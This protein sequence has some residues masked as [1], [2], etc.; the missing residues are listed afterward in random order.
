M[1]LSVSPI[2]LIP[3]LIILSSPQSLRSEEFVS[4][5]KF[6]SNVK[7]DEDEL[8][9]VISLKEA[10]ALRPDVVDKAIRELYAT[11][12][13]RSI[14]V[15]GERAEERIIITF[16]LYGKDIV[17]QI[18]FEGNRFITSKRLRRNIE[19]EVNKLYYED[20]LKK[21]VDQIIGLY[22]DRSFFRTNVKPFIKGEGSGSVSVDFKIDEGSMKNIDILEFN[23]EIEEVREIFNKKFRYGDVYYDKDKFEESIEAITEYLIDRGY[24]NIKI[25]SPELIYES[26]R[27]VLKVRLNIEPGIKYQ[28]EFKGNHAYETDELLKLINF[29]THKSGFSSLL[30]DEWKQKLADV[31]QRNGYA[32][33]SVEIAEI[34]ITKNEHILSFK[35]NEG[36]PMRVKEIKFQGNKYFDDDRIKGMMLTKERGLFSGN[37]DFI[38]D[39]M[40]DYYPKGILIQSRLKEDIENIEY[41]YKEAGFLNASINIK[42]IDYISDNGEIVINILIREGERIF[43]KDVEFEGNSTFTDDELKKIVKIEPRKPFN[44]WIADEGIKLLKNHYDEN[45][46]IFSKIGIENIFIEG[47]NEV[48][49]KYNIDEGPEAYVS[50]VFISGN[51]VTK[52]YVLRRELSFSEGD[53]L[54]PK[55][56]FESQRKIYRLGFIDR[57]SIDIKN[58]EPDGATDI[59][60]K[61]KESKFNRFDIRFGYGTAEGLRSSIEFTK[62][63]LGGRGQTIFARADISYWL[64]D[65]NPFSDIFNSEENYFNTKIFNVGFI[66]PWLFRQNMDLRINYINQER[67]RIY[68]LRSNDIIL[69][70]ERDL[71]RHYH[72][73]VQYQVRFRDPI[74]DIQPDLR[75]EEKRRLGFLGFF[76][77]HDTRNNPFEPYK[78]HLQTYRIDFASRNLVPGGEYDYL[79]F[80]IKGDFFTRPIKK[81]VTA[82]SVRSGYGYVLGGGDIP[83]EERFFLGGTTSVRGFEEDSLGPVVFNPDTNKNTPAGGDFMIGYN[84]ELRWSLRKGLGFVIFTDGGN[85]WAQPDEAN[86]GKIVSFRDLRESAGVGLRY[87]TPIGPL[88]IDLGLK[89]D[90]RRNEPLNEWHFFVG[91]MF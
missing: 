6:I 42:S 50:R 70:I 32:M 66:W 85:V 59:E 11:E 75:Y 19:L 37:I 86:F 44:P 2:V 68:Q 13:F 22:R 21:S 47:T 45:G 40:F 87:A 15:Y 43:V 34:E 56:I 51:D 5:I 12:L 53:K 35:I 77:F 91:N 48:L 90:K 72:G 49:L 54:T 29:D 28:I 67:R 88:R 63:D 55:G 58:V 23:C 30:L 16:Y 80:F 1:N 65:F 27:N 18:N 7:I 74:G 73:G 41:Q 61:V 78:G 33:I 82:F 31:Y 64:R 79:K 81:L 3:I 71:T 57:A 38:Y 17:K 24:W 36:V 89:L 84:V 8:R 4:S 10:E 83:I 39:W 52:G 76:L 9:L 25:S 69:G 62:K 20:S 60:V 14:A 46:F 26:S